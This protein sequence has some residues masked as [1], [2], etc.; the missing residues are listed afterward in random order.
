MLIKE[1]RAAQLLE[2]KF[3][4]H[5][6]KVTKKYDST[7]IKSGGV[8]SCCY[9]VKRE[10]DGIEQVGFLKAIDYSDAMKAT[11]NPVELIQNITNAY[12]YEKK[13]LTLCLERGLNNIVRL[14][15]SGGLDVE[16]AP[17]Y[18][19][20]EYLILEHADQGDVRN[21]LSKTEVNFEWKV[22]SI[23]QITKALSQLHKIGIAHQDVKPSNVVNFGLEK[24]KLTDLGSACSKDNIQ[25]ELPRHL[26]DRYSGSFEYS[27]PELLYGNV[28]GIFEERRILC[29][30]YLLGSMIVFYFLDMS[31]N[32]LLKTNLDR[33]LWWERP[34]MYGKFEYV[35]PYL[36]E[37]FE[38]SLSD[39]RN[40]I[41]FEDVKDDLEIAL[42][43]LCNPDPSRRGHSK[44]LNQKFNQFGLAR[45]LSTFDRIVKKYQYR[46][47]NGLNLQ[48]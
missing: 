46:N 48:Y 39:F 34:E 23:H 30:L 24:T 9:E 42:R 36:T 29:D 25:D 11:D 44:N 37:A 8:Y 19:R 47:T 32:A 22:R 1:N 33:K 43:Y 40:A 15:E 20:V 10:I 17:K 5:G 2:D 4:G 31:M 14:V 38:K 7:E 6:W 16:E 26:Q 28:S 18:P 35:K 13:I 21:V 41:E 45:F 12:Q 27:P 3:I